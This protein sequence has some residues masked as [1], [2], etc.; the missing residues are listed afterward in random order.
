MIDTS[1]ADQK[2]MVRVPAVVTVR[3]PVEER[4][5]IE[6]HRGTLMAYEGDYVIT[7]V[8]DEEYPVSPEYYHRIF[9]EVT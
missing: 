9:E 6:T 5:E 1:D 2:V 8:Q 4:E 3:G 7:D